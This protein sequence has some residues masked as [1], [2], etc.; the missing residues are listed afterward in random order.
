MPRLMMGH[1][2]L[3][4]HLLVSA[5]FVVSLGFTSATPTEKPTPD[6]L[7]ANFT[8][9]HN[10][11]LQGQQYCLKWCKRAQLNATANVFSDFEVGSGSWS[12]AMALPPYEGENQQNTARV[13]NRTCCHVCTQECFTT[14][15]D[16]R[17]EE[18]T[19]D[20]TLATVVTMERLDAVVQM[21]KVW[22]G[23][24]VLMFYFLV[25]P[26]G[27]TNNTA[28]VATARQQIRT[29][30]AK[31]PQTLVLEYVHRSHLELPLLPINALR[32][33][34]LDCARTRY[35]FPVDADF[36]PSVGM[37]DALQNAARELLNKGARAL[38]VPHFEVTE[39]RVVVMRL[40]TADEYPRNFTALHQML[41]QGV[42]RPFHAE[43][44]EILTGLRGLPKNYGCPRKPP[45]LVH[46][47]EG[48]RVTRYDL[49]YDA[50]RVLEGRNATELP[51]GRPWPAGSMGNATEWFQLDA[52]ETD[53]L[54]D[55]KNP[56]YIDRWEPYVCFGRVSA[57]GLV[58][59]Y[60]ELL[61]GR[62]Y[63]KV[64]LVSALRAK[65]FRFYTLLRHFLAHKS[66]RPSRWQ[67]KL[68]GWFAVRMR[69]LVDSS[70]RDVKR[71]FG[72]CDAN[73]LKLVA[74]GKRPL[75]KDKL[76]V[77]VRPLARVSGET[78]QRSSDIGPAEPRPERP[79]LS[80][81]QPSASLP[82]WP[83]P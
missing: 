17:A 6:Q 37:H 43:T 68:G 78:G 4:P 42:M 7:W 26:T 47:I 30:V 76:L 3:L 64:Q 53:N 5:L 58:M 19:A 13:F 73:N 65:R 57:K 28:E 70:L 39:C 38:V 79:P 75:V 77:E 51:R 82:P 36:L 56:T 72:G 18:H 71:S 34:A 67:R 62:F 8:R 33:A 31:W 63:N 60:N 32:N 81:V 41:G 12:R 29:L 1:I 48:I 44:L 21:R 61:V 69:L 35:L 22:S 52:S 20:V 23:P 54:C 2:A 15:R 27:P 24:M 14:V 83:T 74:K 55:R 25:L 49:W 66:H 50:S 59:R 10:D 80:C 16:S 9:N 45:Q 40:K 11:W 46:N